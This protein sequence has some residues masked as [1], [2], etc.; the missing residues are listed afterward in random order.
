MKNELSHPPQPNKSSSLFDTQECTIGLIRLIE[1][2]ND[3][4]IQI[5]LMGGFANIFSFPP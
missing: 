2:P 3:V 1:P 4:K 5:S